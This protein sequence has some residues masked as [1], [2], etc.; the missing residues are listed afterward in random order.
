MK[1]VYCAVRTEFIS[2]IR[3]KFRVQRFNCK[4]AGTPDVTRVKK[5]PANS[6][7]RPHTWIESR[8]SINGLVSEIAS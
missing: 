2:V 1:G 3:F 8:G 7:T 5:T 6:V 4:P